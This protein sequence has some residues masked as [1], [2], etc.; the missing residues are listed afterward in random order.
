MPTN[1]IQSIPRQESILVEIFTGLL[2]IAVTPV[3]I[4]VVLLMAT[5]GF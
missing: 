5:G 2:A 4:T 3:L 1:P